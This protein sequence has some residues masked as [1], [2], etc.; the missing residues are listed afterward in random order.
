[1]TQ[2]LKLTVMENGIT[3]E[4]THIEYIAWLQLQESK[5]LSRVCWIEAAKGCDKCTIRHICH[6]ICS[7][8]CKGFLEG[9]M[10]KVEVVDE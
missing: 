3:R 10:V 8:H 2:K 9:K 6:Q 5:H 1:M 7:G 4:A